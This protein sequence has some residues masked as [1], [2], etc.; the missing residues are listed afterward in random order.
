MGLFKSKA[1]KELERK[2]A[3]RRAMSEMEKRIAK[4]KSQEQV[5]RD[6]ANIAMRESLPEQIELATKALQLTKGEE[7]RTYQMLLNLRIISQ[8]KDMSAMTNS[9]V[10]ALRQIGKS[11]SYNTAKDMRKLVGEIESA[12]ENVASQTEAVM[13]V[14]ELNQSAVSNLADKVSPADKSEYNR[15]IYGNNDSAVEDQEIEKK[16]ASLRKE[17]NQ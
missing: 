17:I 4:L 11:I 15:M 3:V 12:M 6:A 1:E 5:Y 10:T 8:M 9:F 7:K 2:M 13:D 16:L 14:M